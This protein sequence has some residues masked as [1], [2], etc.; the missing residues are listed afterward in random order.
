MTRARHLAWAIIVSATTAAAAPSGGPYGPIDTRYAIPKAPH[1][2]YVAPDGEANAAGTALAAPTTL[3]TAVAKAVT[4]D[5]II[6]RG[7]VYRTGGLFFNQKIIFQPYLGEHPVLKGTEVATNWQ[8]AG[9][10]VW[11][12]SWTALFPAAPL[13]WW[14]RDKEEAATPL[15][16]FNND[17]VFVDGV[18]LQSAGS[19]AEVKPDTYYIDYAA[20]EVYVGIDPA[21]HTVEITAHDGALIRTSGPVNGKTNDFKGPIIRGLTITGYARRCLE[22]EGKRSFGPNDEPTDEPIGKA[23]ASTYGK[24]AVGTVLE[25]L[26]I[27]YCSRVGGWF[28]GDHMV[29][30]NNLFSDTST[31]GIYVIASSDVLIE[32]NIVRRNNIE[33]LTGYYP[34]AVKIF[35]QTH[36]V[37]MRD[38]LI[39]EN[40]NSNGVWFDVGN[41]DAVF[42]N[43][44]VEGALV[45]FFFEIS[46]GATVAGN[47]FV[48]NGDGARALNSRD[49]HMYNNTFIDNPAR[50]ERT[51]RSNIGDHFAWHPTTGPDV[52]ERQG[53]IFVNNLMVASANYRKPLL[54][55]E[56]ASVLCGKLVTSPLTTID[57]N[58]YVRPAD[59]S[60]P[61]AL[62]SPAD[63]PDCTAK[64]VTLEALHQVAPGVDAKGRQIDAGPHGIFKAPDLARYELIRPL[65][66]AT[67]TPAA[68]LKLMGWKK[69][70]NAGAYPTTAKP[71]KTAKTAKK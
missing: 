50:F 39:L 52:G 66:A 48:R 32:R 29:I 20:K 55:V 62:W 10:N 58:V 1:V 54:R 61:V 7:G 3:A 18:F 21:A 12:T 27:S 14:R 9:A 42:V 16:R 15:H 65:P 24:Q 57:G 68:V 28:R 40:P 67:Q 8:P 41:H 13:A 4:G 43:N 25:N 35:N 64:P 36:N 6:L 47:V 56:Q 60:G 46:N 53:H 51:E 63:A 31:E 34:G 19:V 38:N 71:A 11:K 30:R 17:M 22:V 23:D 45:G 2:Y 44:Y 37:V 26:T 70:G 5:A 59:I 49:V 33:N 69:P